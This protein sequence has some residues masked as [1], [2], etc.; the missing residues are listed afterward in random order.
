MVR[1]RTERR[2]AAASRRTVLAIGRK[3]RRSLAT[4]R[5]LMSDE[6]EKE[7]AQK[8]NNKQN[9]DRKTTSCGSIESASFA[10][11]LNK[12]DA[13]ICLIVVF[14]VTAFFP[15]MQLAAFINNAGYNSIQRPSDLWAPREIFAINQRRSRFFKVRCF[16]VVSIYSLLRARTVILQ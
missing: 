8:N 3:N 16:T 6:Q 13:A 15:F 5:R 1:A 4:G 10:S 11:W 9:D 2:D 12:S 7:N 14:L